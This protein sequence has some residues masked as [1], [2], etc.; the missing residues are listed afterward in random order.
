VLNTNWNR[1]EWSVSVWAKPL[2][3]GVWSDSTARR[4]MQFMAGTTLTGITLRKTTT[5]NEFRINQYMNNT[6]HLTIKF[7]PIL[8][9]LDSYYGY[10]Q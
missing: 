5:S 10:M 9:N 1:S 2:N 7:K 3:S 8:D 6:S 4:P